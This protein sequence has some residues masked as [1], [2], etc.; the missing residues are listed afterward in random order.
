MFQSN[1]GNAPTRYSDGSVEPNHI[2]AL[3]NVTYGN[4]VGKMITFEGI[5]I[6]L[7]SYGSLQI[8]QRKLR[9]EVLILA[10]IG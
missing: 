6:G 2:T 10:W 7:D 1:K 8:V 9:I 4:M 5:H 3:S